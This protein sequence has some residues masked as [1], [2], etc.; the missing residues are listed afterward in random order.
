MTV[1]NA[2]LLARAFAGFRDGDL[3]A[4]QALLHPDCELV[5]PDSI[6]YG[7]NFRGAEEVY[8][9]FARQLWRWFDEFSSTPTGF[10]DAGDQIVV[11]VHVAARA[12]NGTAV[13]VDNVWIYEFAESKLVRGTVYA[14]T[15]RLRDAVE[16]VV[17]D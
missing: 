5:V 7:G 10:I 9:W 2:E 13:E 15:A 11:P 16:G 8:G 17:P 6:P 14:D 4:L 3:T 1:S 12:K